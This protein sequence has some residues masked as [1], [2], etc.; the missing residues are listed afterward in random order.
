MS[1]LAQELAL[2]F[3]I[4]CV[5][6]YT[7]TPSSLAFLV[8]DSGYFCFWWRSQSDGELLPPKLLSES[9]PPRLP[10]PAPWL[11]FP[12]CQPL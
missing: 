7:G 8:L 11:P 5:L 1:A 4:V 12:S 2:P 9:V 10:H 6:K 3:F